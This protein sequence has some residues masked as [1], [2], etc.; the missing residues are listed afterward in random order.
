MTCLSSAFRA[1]APHICLGSPAGKAMI[2]ACLGI[3]LFRPG[4]DAGRDFIGTSGN[5]PATMKEAFLADPVAESVR[6]RKALL[7]QYEAVAPAGRQPGD[8]SPFS[9][10]GRRMSLRED[11]SLQ[12]QAARLAA[13]P[14]S[15]ASNWARVSRPSRRYERAQSALNA[16][17]HGLRRSTIDP[18]LR[19][20][21][22]SIST[23]TEKARRS[24]YSLRHVESG[25]R[26]RSAP[27][28]R[29]PEKT[30]RAS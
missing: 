11:G 3:A 22:L 13:A 23:P 15:A 12:E 5:P 4:A 1:R 19:M 29:R 25:S 17:A 28:R 20:R 14:G 21:M 18:P 10:T 7:L 8:D 2:T 16:C 26:R 6:N 30:G 27:H 24:R 9:A